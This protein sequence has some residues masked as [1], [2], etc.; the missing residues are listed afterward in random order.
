MLSGEDQA[1][2]STLRMTPAQRE[3]LRET[4]IRVFRQGYAKGQAQ[5]A[6]VSGVIESNI[7]S[8][9]NV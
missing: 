2:L 3:Q 9:F 1:K 7:D 4:I 8:D 6:T 5:A